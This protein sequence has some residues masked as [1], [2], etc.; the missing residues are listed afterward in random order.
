R[1][2][3]ADRGLAPVQV[4]QVAPRP[5]VVLAARLQ[6]LLPAVASDGHLHDLGRALVD[7]GDAYVA[8]DLLDHVLVRVAI[9]TERLDGGLGRRVAGLGGE[10]FGDGAL[11][12]WRPASATRPGGALLP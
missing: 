2:V 11:G 8:L 5:V 10:V 7:G 4:F 6:V 12:F 9:A 3:R 1:H